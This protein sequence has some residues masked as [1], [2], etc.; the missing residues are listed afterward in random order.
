[1]VEGRR[2]EV[3]ITPSVSAMILRASSYIPP[4][5]AERNLIAHSLARGLLVPWFVSNH[6]ASHAPLLLH[7]RI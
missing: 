6:L 7:R 5:V 1:M 2:F 4:D 3:E